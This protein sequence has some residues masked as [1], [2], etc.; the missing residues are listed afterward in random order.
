MN[1]TY[2][3]LRIKRL[4]QF[5]KSWCVH[6]W[7]SFTVEAEADQSLRV[8]ASLIYIMISRPVLKARPSK[9]SNYNKLMLFLIIEY[10]V[11]KG[12]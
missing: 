2:P 3:L 6:L 11:T 12:K 5:D 9:K 7:F 4:I 8:E 1:T 10:M